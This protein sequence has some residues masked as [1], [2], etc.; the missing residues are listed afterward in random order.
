MN[1]PE[2]REEIESLYD[3]DFF[4]WT[5]TASEDLLRGRISRSDIEHI[6]EEIADMGKRD[7]RE[8]ESRARVLIMHLLKWAYQPERRVGSTWLRTIKTQRLEIKRNLRDSPSLKN[9]IPQALQ[10][11]YREACDLAVDEMGGKV[12]FPR[13]CPFTPEQILSDWL[14]D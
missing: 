11:I 3:I 2:I 8:V 13:A 14:P 5:Q 1:K 7:R 9:A 12:S 4:E 6:A 10:R